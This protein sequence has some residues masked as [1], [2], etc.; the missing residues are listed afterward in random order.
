MKKAGIFQL[1]KFPIFRKFLFKLTTFILKTTKLFYSDK[2]ATEVEVLSINSGN[3]TYKNGSIGRNNADLT[4]EIIA[5]TAF[6]VISGLER[7]RV[8]YLSDLFDLKEIEE[9]YGNL[10]TIKI[11]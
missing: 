8:Y 6:Q 3:M 1:L 5:Y 11:D 10:F 7:Y 4:G 2:Y 9:K